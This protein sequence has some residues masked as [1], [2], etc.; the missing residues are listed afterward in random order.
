MKMKKSRLLRYTSNIITLFLLVALAVT[1]FS[2]IRSRLYPGQAASIFGFQ[3]LS[4]LTGSMQP[5]LIP[6]DMIVI[7]GRAAE[8]IRPGDVVTYRVGGDTLVTHRVT[9]VVEQDGEIR[10]RTKGDAN[11]VEDASLTSP[12]QLL[13]VMA[14]RIPHGG[15]AAKFIRSPYGLII[16]ILLP[17]GV[18]LSSEVKSLL[19]ETD[20]GKKEA[21]LEDSMQG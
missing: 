21:G 1:A 2:F 10:F 14:L 16:F 11:N 12:Q 7:R 18:L 17:L 8:D 13:G 3:P 6:G 20:A 5:A 9:E 4:V 19:S 15:Y